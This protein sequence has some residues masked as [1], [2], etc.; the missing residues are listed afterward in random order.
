MSE[1]LPPAPVYLPFQAGAY[2]PAMGLM[3]QP[4]DQLTAFDDQ[5]LDQMAQRRILLETRRD[6]VLA[7]TPGSGAMCAEAL[8]V[9]VAHLCA[10][11]AAWFSRCDN[12]LTNHLTGETWALDRLD[13]DPLE[14]AGR[15]VVED[16]CLLAPAPCPLLAAAVLCFPSRWRL[17]D[18]IGQPLSAI[19]APVPDYGPAL[20]GPVD[21]FL[22][23]LK[24]G[25]LVERMNWSI[26]DDAALFQPEAVHAP[27]QTI[28]AAN[29][30]ALLTMRIE[31]QTLSRLPQTGAILFT[32]RTY[33]H[34]LSRV[35][36]VPGAAASLRAALAALPDAV[37][38]YKGISAFRAALE[39]YLGR[40]VEVEGS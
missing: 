30:G 2:R 21:R 38:A 27:R 16:I 37:A 40:F 25:R 31:R 35:A 3:A 17:A 1:G 15:L 11:R 9:L 14:L 10:D 7:A 26:H 22:G 39:G 13:H 18:K 36:A 32:I 24:P 4:L 12:K 34:R 33:Q 5:Y 20:S 28:T 29:A 19:H 23:L 8:A 6:E